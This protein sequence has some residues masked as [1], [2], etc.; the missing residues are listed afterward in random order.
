MFDRRRD[1]AI[2]DLIETKPT[3]TKLLNPLV[4]QDVK[5]IIEGTAL[6]KN[7][8]FRSA[9]TIDIKSL[10]HLAT[11]EVT[12]REHLV[13]ASVRLAPATSS[14]LVLIG[15]LR[16]DEHGVLYVIEELAEREL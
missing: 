6:G 4:L 11:V 14:H 10:G 5:V 12:P 7:Y 8:R 15:E 3:D 16:P 2:T 13:D 9:A 1:H